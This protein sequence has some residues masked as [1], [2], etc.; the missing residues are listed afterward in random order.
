MKKLLR[1][2][3]RKDSH[4]SVHRASHASRRHEVRVAGPGIPLPLLSA[5][6]PRPPPPPG[7][8]PSPLSR[9]ARTVT[10]A[11]L[12]E[13]FLARAQQVGVNSFRAATTVHVCFPVLPAASTRLARRPHAAAAPRAAAP[14]RRRPALDSCPML[15]A[16]NHGQNNDFIILERVCGYRRYVSLN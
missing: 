4:E 8:S 6:L 16:S 11:S 9:R 12:A 3:A 5:P 2:D 14:P 1:N 7:P 15:T 13:F 10:P